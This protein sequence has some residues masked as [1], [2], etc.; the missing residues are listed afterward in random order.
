M[1]RI[2]T[3]N[4]VSSRTLELPQL[5]R[6]ESR[7]NF[8]MCHEGRNV[9]TKS[10]LNS[11]SHTHRYKKHIQATE[12][13]TQKNRDRVQ[14]LHVSLNPLDIDKLIVCNTQALIW[15]SGESVRLKRQATQE[16]GVQIPT[17]PWVK[18]LSLT[19]ESSKDET[20]WRL[21]SGDWVNIELTSMIFDTQLTNH[22]NLIYSS[23]NRGKC[24]GKLSSRTLELPQSVKIESR[25]DFYMCQKGVMSAQIE[26]EF[27][28]S[29]T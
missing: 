23:L 20:Q 17:R 22:K 29:Q 2:I 16:Y 6:I 14:V 9:C 3:I 11:R 27:K 18:T 21:V 15:P 19:D 7:M 10:K 13:V 24:Q 8:Y 26:R 12:E 4:K 5:V 28:V 25:I 1:Q